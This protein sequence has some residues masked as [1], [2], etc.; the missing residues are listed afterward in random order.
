MADNKIKYGL[1]N[2]HIASVTI[3]QG[4]AVTFGT[5]EALPGAKSLSLEP[6]GETSDFYADNEIFYT[7]TKNDGYTG[8][9]EMAELT[10]SFIKSYLGATE[11]TNKLLVERSSDEPKY[12]AL[13]YQFEGDAK[14]TKHIL[15]YCKAA[16]PTDSAATAE[17]SVEPGTVSLEF[18]AQPLPGSKVVKSKTIDGTTAS[19]YS[20]WFTSAPVVPTF[21]A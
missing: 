2:V 14:A 3:A 20:T 18:T 15:Y 8:T 11:S 19:T 5:P 9:L 7:A 1:C 12:F 4:G 13:L 10:P 16:R 6:K 17:G 21:S